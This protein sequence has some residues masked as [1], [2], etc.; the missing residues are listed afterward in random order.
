MKPCS[1]ETWAGPSA[2]EP[3]SCAMAKKKNGK[4]GKKDKRKGKSSSDAGKSR[5][6]DVFDDGSSGLDF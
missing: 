3:E 4:Q 6:R 1:A 5:D 2:S